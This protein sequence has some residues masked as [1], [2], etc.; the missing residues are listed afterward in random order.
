MLKLLLTFFTPWYVSGGKKYQFFRKF[1]ERNKWMIPTFLSHSTQLIVIDGILSRF[2]QPIHR[3]CGNRSFNM[4]SS[5]HLL[6]LILIRANSSNQFQISYR[7]TPGDFN[8]TVVV[9]HSGRTYAETLRWAFASRGLL[10]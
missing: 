3:L 2:G 7:S 4:R 9:V 5:S 6:R 10:F 8:L 1:C